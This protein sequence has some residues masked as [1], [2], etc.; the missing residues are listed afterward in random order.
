M[1][2]PVCL[3]TGVGPAKGTGAEVAKRFSKGGYQVAMLARNKD[4]LAEL[5]QSIKGTTAFPCDV[6]DLEALINTIE[7]IRKTPGNPT[8][9]VYNAAKSSRGSIL[10]LDPEDLE[11]NFRVNTTALL[12][13][14]RE[15]IPAMLN[16]GHGAILITGN[17]SATR[18]I[19]N[20]GFF[21]STKASQRILAEAIAREFGPQGIHIAYFIIDA[22]IDTP[23]T[24]PIIGAGKPDEFFAKASAI[25]DEMFHIAHQ[26]KSTWSFNI[27]LRPFGEKW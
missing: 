8:V 22:L 15:T 21:A 6:G 3:V 4:N 16:V 1:S 26:D 7:Q 2:K 23:R 5:E 24:R 12:Y 13:L 9:V 14:A 11:R 10:E 18:G 25:A 20:W 17:T 19:T 27:E